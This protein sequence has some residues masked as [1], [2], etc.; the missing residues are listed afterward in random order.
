MT[1]SK[2]APRQSHAHATF[3]K[4]MSSIANDFRLLTPLVLMDAVRRAGTTVYEPVHRFH[5]EGPTAALGAILRLL[6]SIDAVPE[7]PQHLRSSILLRGVIPAA[8]LQD[9]RQQL[10]GLTQGDGFV[11]STFDSYRRAHG[12]VQRRDR[13]GPDPLD[14]T[15]YLRDIAA[16]D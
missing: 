2:Y 4:N 5:L 14:R 11:E 7:P 1:A 16:R 9:L 15:A 3:D 12:P 10:P 8:R 6:A 13:T